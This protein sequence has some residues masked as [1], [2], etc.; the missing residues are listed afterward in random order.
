VAEG[1]G[2]GEI[3]FAVAPF[4]NFLHEVDDC[5][6]EPILQSGAPPLRLARAY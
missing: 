2:R 5:R 1:A 4:V 3:G 6:A